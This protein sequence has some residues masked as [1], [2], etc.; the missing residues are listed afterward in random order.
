MSSKWFAVALA[1]A[2]QAPAIGNEIVVGQIG[3]FTVLPAPDAAQLGQ[4]MKAFFDQAN[5]R[6]GLHG[7]PIVF[8]QLDDTY[9]ADGFVKQF[10]EALKRK[11]LALLTPVGSAAIKR[12]LDDKLLA[13]AD[14]LVLNAIPGAEALR[15]PGH[16]RMFHL[17]AGDREQIEKIVKHLRTLGMSSLAVLHQDLLMGSSGLAVA[18]E[19]AQRA[20]GLKVLPVK[21]SADAAALSQAARQVSSAGVQ[22]VLVIGAPKFMTDAVVELRKAGVSQ[23]LFALSYVPAA[24]LVKA[25]GA[26]ARG[27][28]IAQAFPNPMSI[29]LPIQRE[30]QVAMRKS[31]PALAGY[32]V[33]HLEGYITAKTFHEAA[34]RCKDCG[35]DALAKTLRTMGELDLGGFRVNFANGNVGSSFVDIGVV[36][37]QGRLV[38]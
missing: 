22:S 26:G 28:G 10:G 2:L 17:R 25:A 4:G 15:K 16:P 20:G 19:A 8:F 32:T 21:S 18:E 30:F 37:E 6:G 36:N 13:E 35:A 29:S 31:F 3:P 34:R 9:S 38:Y 33:F 23:S 11:P 12:M 24:A 27:V 7:R 1:F 5:A 14:V